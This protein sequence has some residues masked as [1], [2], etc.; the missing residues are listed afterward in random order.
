MDLLTQRTL[1]IARDALD[2]DDPAERL[3]CVRRLAGGDAELERRVLQLLDG[4]DAVGH[5]DETEPERAAPAD[6]FQAGDLFGAYRLL[7]PLGSGGMGAVWLAERADGAFERQVALKLLRGGWLRPDRHFRRERDILARLGH[8]NIAQLYDGGASGDQPWFALEYV[9]GEPITAWCDRHRLDVR[10]RVRLLLPICAAVQFAHQNLVVHR[11]IKPANVLVAEDGTPKLLDFGI[12]RLVGQGDLRQTQT[13]AMTPAY[14]SP[15]QRRGDP[16]GTPSDVYQLGLLLYEL[17]AGHA[18]H[19]LRQADPA[20][21]LPRLDLTVQAVPETR[22]REVA[23]ARGTS[24]ERLRAQLRG[25]LARIVAKAMAAA[26]VERYASPQAFAQ[27]LE[28]WLAGRP[29]RAHRGSLAYRTHKFLRRN[30]PASLAAL[31]MLAA[32]A[33]YVVDLADK[34]RRIATERDQALVIAGFLQDLFRGAN[35]QE[36]GEP[37]LS[38]RELLDRGVARL[39]KETRLEA[40]TRAQLEATMARSYQGLGLYEAARALYDRALVTFR[41]SGAD[42]S[43]LLARTI[44]DGASSALEASDTSAAE[45]S[46]S[47]AQ[48]V[49][50]AGQVDDLDLAYAHAAAAISLGN[51]QRTA[52]ADPHYAAI[53]RLRSDVFAKDPRFFAEMSLIQADHESASQRPERAVDAARDA[54][55]LNREALGDKAPDTAR[56]L[57][58][59][60]DMLLDLR[61]YEEAEQNYRTGVARLRETFGPRHREVGVKLSNLGLLYLRLGRFDEA[62][63]TLAEALEILTEVYGTDHEYLLPAMTYLAWAAFEAGDLDTSRGYVE[64]AERVAAADGI[65]DTYKA[66]VHHMR[67]RLACRDGE[68]APARREFD[69]AHAVYTREHAVFLGPALLAHHAACLAASGHADE[70]RALLPEAIRGLREGVGEQ[71]WDTREA[72]A[73]QQRLQGA[74]ATR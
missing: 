71:A 27:D 17:L 30:W 58:T 22:R 46:L 72:E 38:A 26:E 45:R 67:S 65:A 32:S 7:R 35:P 48:A 51:L 16:V 52:E 12:A 43:T 15:E 4:A 47:E 11:D 1:N 55:A 54:V 2:V 13:L 21:R 34:N 28:A 6:A 14:A 62:R 69:A 64:R 53:A 8:P 61:R 44:K 68:L 24:P 10:T 56:A 19:D 40:R 59:L 3:A 9:A 33:Y 73:L 29:V 42:D 50:D 37:D 63:T 36:T 31:A 39:D 70:A 41:E 57:V 74:A 25:D 20:R 23:L 18:A 60:A 49:I 66:R 5:D